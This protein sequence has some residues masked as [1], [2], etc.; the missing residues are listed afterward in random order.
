MYWKMQSRLIKCIVFL[1][2]K[3]A[4]VEFTEFSITVIVNRLCLFWS[5]NVLC[6]NL[7]SLNMLVITQWN[8]SLDLLSVKLVQ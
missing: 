5:Q 2:K 3:K 8:R 1:C 6:S 4:E 7:I